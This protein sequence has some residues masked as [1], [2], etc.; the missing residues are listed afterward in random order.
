MNPFSPAATPANAAIA[1][2]RFGLGEPDLAIVTPDPRSWLLAQIGP[3]EAQRGGDLPGIQVALERQMQA[4]KAVQVSAAASAG[5]SA[6]DPYRETIAADIRARLST[7]ASTARPFAERLALFWS[8]HFSVSNA[9]GSSRGLVGA[10]EREAI[11]PHIAG[12]FA[13]MLIAS[14]THPAMLRYLDNSQSAGPNSRAVTAAR[15][16]AQRQPDSA[17]PRLTGLNENLGREVLELHTLGVAEH[18]YSQAD[19]TALAAV[20]SGWRGPVPDRP[21]NASA[22]DAS[23]FDANWHEPGDKTV[24]GQRWPEGPQALPALLRRL[25]Q[26]P[27]TAR[28][29][30]TKLARHFVADVPPP[31]LVERLAS[32]YLDSGGDL[33]AV[34]AALVGS[35][36]AWQVAP[37]KLKSPEEFVISSARLLRLGDKLADRMRGAPDAGIAA[38]GQ[39]LQAPTSPAGW[40]D[41]AED[42]IGPEAVWKRVE[43]V[44]R[45]AERMGGTL[46]ARALAVASLGPRLTEATRIEIERAADGTQALSLLLLAPEFQRR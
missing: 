32:A 29:I 34:Y 37:Q 12:K 43:W 5:E 23:G 35:P 42:W 24:L 9:K 25:A 38:L 1:A 11:R 16:R 39:R 33:P 40:P 45:L 14:T 7:S 21:A 44:A 19:V 13:D 26:H 36:E 18:A 28:F 6:K 4:R 22:P 41:R 20:L 17:P 3:A 27:S 2:H 31:A 15:R 10:F 46:D 30:S 8:N